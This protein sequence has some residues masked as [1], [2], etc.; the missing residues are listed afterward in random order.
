MKC[1]IEKDG[2]ISLKHKGSWLL[3]DLYPGVD[4]KQIHSLEVRREEKEILW[5]TAEGEIR[6]QIKEET[7]QDAE[8]VFSL[9]N[10]STKIHTLSFFYQGKTEPQGF[11]Q[12]A[13]GM[14]G[15][16]GYYGRES[17]LKN[18]NTARSGL[19]SLDF[20]TCALA[21]YT[22]PERES[23]QNKNRDFREYR[24]ETVFEL[25]AWERE[26]YLKGWGRQKKDKEF[27]LSCCARLEYTN[28]KDAVFAPI[29]FLITD[30][31]EQSLEQ[32]ASEI[33][34]KLGARTDK[35]PAFFW[36]SWYYC[37]YNFDLIKLKQY[38]AQLQSMKPRTPFQYIQI[39]AGYFPSAGDWLLASERY[40]GGMKEAFDEII[41][42]GYKPGIWIGPYM[43]GNRSLLFR[44]H[45][46]WILR[47]LEGEPLKALIMDNEPKMWGRQ[48]EE[49]YVLDTSHPDA[50][51]YMRQVFRTFRSWGASMFKTDFMLWGF[52]DSSRVRRHTPGKT[53]VEY[54]REFL[55]M[56]FETIGEESYW[57]G[58]IA[59]FQPF[60]GYANGMRV[61]GDVG[62]C[63]EGEYGPQSL[64]RCLAGSNYM[65][66]NYYQTDPDAVMLR[67][68][69]IRLTERE[70]YSLALLAAVSGSCIYTSDPLFALS[71]ERQK[72]FRFIQP[73][74]KRRKPY[75]PFLGQERRE[76]VM[77]HKERTKGLIYI[78]NKSEETIKELY[79]M[80]E[81]GFSK[82]WKVWSL[83]KKEEEMLWQ[84]ILVTEIPPH[85]CRLYAVSAQKKEI[86]SLENLW[87]FFKD[88]EE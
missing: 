10:W 34:K 76:I 1:E 54:F 22:L 4:G 15:D 52:Q 71:E 74:G 75:L 33:G 31:I 67:D 24:Y 2:T 51:E 38:L 28:G 42:A 44:E 55:Q 13:R 17:L 68:F 29:K 30:T 26:K 53:S 47:N 37:Y 83:E 82:N 85:G 21:I 78:L 63:W 43:V 36:S 16:T 8:L 45:P 69:H 40:A 20:G 41:K 57:L 60:I 9:S 12:T 6:C 39:D 3:K 46:D 27:R 35:P 80:E 49:Y 59:P 7:E 50:M 73:D 81:L 86:K 64:L 72:L 70:I 58:C 65:N 62:A 14:E 56:I 84:G 66:H 18:R 48:D 25:D 77:V 87:G 19:C 23:F 5:K 32:A 61:G 79:S 11:Y 88:F